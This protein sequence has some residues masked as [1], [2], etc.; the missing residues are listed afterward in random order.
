MFD[1]NELPALS[2]YEWAHEEKHAFLTRE[3]CELTRHHAARCPEYHKMLAASGVD[4]DRVQRFEELPFLPVRLFKEFSLKS[5]PDEELHK[6]MTS[7][8]TTGQQVS[9]I[10]LDRETSTLQ[11]KVLSRIVGEFLGKQ[12]LPMIILD[13]S[14]II[15]N[16]AM[17]SARGAGILGFSMFGRDKIYALDENMQLDVEGLKAFLKKHEGED[18]FLFGFTFMIWQHFC[19]ELRKSG[20]RPDLSRGVL[21]HGGGWKKLADQHI[22]TAQFRQAL[23]E[24]CGLTRVHDY[25]GMVEQTGTIY[26]EC[27]CGHLHAPVWSDI[28]IRRPS[29]FGV[30][31]KGALGLIQVSSLLPHSYPGHMLLTEDEGRILGE[32][33]CPCGRKGKY[34]EIIGRIRRAE[35][36]GCSDTYEQK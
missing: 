2:A 11:S 14:A 10:Y 21:I 18:I 25:Y 28:T 6:T 23:H 12:R 8:G 7:S 4:V 13:T 29:D 20:Y 22:T 17:F 36:R 35:V 15:K 31:E 16:R 27:E 3:L 5:V 30:A 34:F 1:V 26:M 33:D 32:D 24:T 9:R 19:A